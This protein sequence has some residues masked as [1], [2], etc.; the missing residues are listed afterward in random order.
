MFFSRPSSDSAPKAGNAR[1][2]ADEVGPV[3]DA[4]GQVLA[5]YT[6]H[7]ID[8]PDRPV[9]EAREELEGWRRH[10]L[11]GTPAPGAVRA[12][13]EAH[14]PGDIAH[15]QW[16][17]MTQAYAS[18]RR[19]ERRY[20]ETALGDLRDAL[21]SC[22]ER[23]HQA[24]LADQQHSPQA[25]AQ[26]TRVRLALDHLE[27]GA[28]K[29]EIAQAMITMEELS[30]ARQHSQRE[31][32]G[33]LAARIAQL[34]SQLE[35]AQRASETD[36]LTGLGNRLAFDR[37]VGRMTALHALSGQPLSVVVIDLDFL[38]VLNDAH[39][40]HVGDAALVT[41]ARTLPRVFLRE[42]DVICR[43][44]GD[45]FGVL[46]PGT[47]QELAMRLTDRFREK[48]AEAPWEYLAQ[49][50]PL[51]ASAGA[52]AWEMPESIPDWV[53]RADAAM[54]QVKLAR[55]RPRL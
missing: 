31:A 24:L 20:V 41:V 49:A 19:D 14:P 54:Y 8:M 13:G 11:M 7:I 53:R 55:T 23:S 46:L 44:G 45:E 5:Q 33:Q 15:R 25:E 3:L 30:R 28:V 9:E 50:G 34:G 43:L 16:V 6:Q 10:V 42:T 32:F 26:V 37:A 52:A 2:A 4:L 29:N 47:T 36:T 27:T 22:V 40:H 12:E 39:G 35:E 18:H 48:L 51:S 1:A 17:G 38:K 21:W